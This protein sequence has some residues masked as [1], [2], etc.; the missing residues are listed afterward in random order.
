LGEPLKLATELGDKRQDR[1]FRGPELFRDLGRAKIGANAL[2]P[3]QPRCHLT[4][5]N[6]RFAAVF[7]SRMRLFPSLAL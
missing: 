4:R 3:C 7:E 6:R 1:A 5:K 2:A